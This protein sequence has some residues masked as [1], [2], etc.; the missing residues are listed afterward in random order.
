M[1]ILI[2]FDF[3]CIIS[4]WCLMLVSTNICG[5]CEAPWSGGLVRHVMSLMVLRVGGS[6][7]TLAFFFY[8]EKVSVLAKDRMRKIKWES[9]EWKK[10]RTGFESGTKTCS[11]MI[12]NEGSLR[13][14]MKW[15]MPSYIFVRR[16]GV[17]NK[18]VLLPFKLL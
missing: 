13:Q 12:K 7:P 18:N 14:A 9:P 6:C 3:L 8:G 4:T 1:A 11:K 5:L 2:F 17:K 15:S 16:D 10:K